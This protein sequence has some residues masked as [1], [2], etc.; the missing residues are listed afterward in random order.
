MSTISQV[1]LF[2]AHVRSAPPTAG[3]M[4]TD[5][6]SFSSVL[7]RGPIR[8]ERPTQLLN[9]PL[10]SSSNQNRR[11]KAEPP[12]GIEKPPRLNQKRNK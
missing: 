3:M 12:L 11:R 1:Q 4:M 6:S 2:C 5:G 8:S 9:R 7:S 10:K